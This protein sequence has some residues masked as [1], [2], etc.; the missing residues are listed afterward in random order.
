MSAAIH[1]FDWRPGLA[2]ERHPSVWANRQGLC[3]T[4]GRARVRPLDAAATGKL[5]IADGQGQEGHCKRPF[6]QAEDI[7]QNTTSLHAPDALF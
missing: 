5:G 2:T 1:G 7:Y 3:L 4:S 6:P